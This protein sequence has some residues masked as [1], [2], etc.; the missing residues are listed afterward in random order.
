M[1]LLCQKFGGSGTAARN[2]WIRLHGNVKV[3][4]ATTFT[5]NLEKYKKTGCMHDQVCI[6]SYSFLGSYSSL[7]F[8]TIASICHKGQAQVNPRNQGPDLWSHHSRSLFATSR[9]ENVVQGVCEWAGNVTNNG[10]ENLE[11]AQAQVHQM[12]WGTYYINTVFENH[13]KSRILCGQK[14][15]KNAKNGA[16]RRAFINLKIDVK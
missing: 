15:I 5:R 1:V 2:E 14:F 3:P 12:Y 16:F 11:R 9:E 10:D 7:Y 8:L 13:R 6:I 4:A